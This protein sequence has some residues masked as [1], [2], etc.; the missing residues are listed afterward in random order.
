M[1]EALDHVHIFPAGQQ[2]ESELDR[3][4]FA[5]MRRIRALN[6][7]DALIVPIGWSQATYSHTLLLVVDRRDQ[8]HFR[9]G[10]VNT[11]DGEASST[12]PPT[13]RTRP[14][15]S[16]SWCSASTTYR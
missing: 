14:T 3:F 16:T 1:S 8:E 5:F 2:S 15:S 7:Q 12:T 10:I 13:P 4:M 6:V 11:T 9:I